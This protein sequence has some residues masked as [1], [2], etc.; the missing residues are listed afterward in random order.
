MAVKWCW[1]PTR[2]GDGYWLVSNGKLKMSCDDNE[3]ESVKREME[4]EFY[5]YNAGIFGCV[6]GDN[7]NDS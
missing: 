1:I 2:G 6:D 4:E 7:N 5:V 3:L